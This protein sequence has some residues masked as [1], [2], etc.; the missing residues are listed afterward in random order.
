[1]TIDEVPVI[2]EEDD[3]KLIESFKLLDQK[4]KFPSVEAIVP[5]NLHR[6]G[7]YQAGAA[8]RA[9]SPDVL[10]RFQASVSNVE[11]AINFLDSAP[12]DSV[13]NERF[14]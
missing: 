5:A 10:G 2:L 14:T 3:F 11:A 1:M 12:T 8:V 6:W 9:D 4:L 7:A 13:Y